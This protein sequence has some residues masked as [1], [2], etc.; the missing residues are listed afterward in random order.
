M[1]RYKQCRHLFFL[2]RRL[3]RKNKKNYYKLYPASTL[4]I[5][6]AP[7]NNAQVVQKKKEVFCDVHTEYR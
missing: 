4:S 7:S 2:T 1:A 3:I 6:W 5:H